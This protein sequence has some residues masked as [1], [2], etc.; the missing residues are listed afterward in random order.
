MKKLSAVLVVISDLH[1][2]NCRILVEDLK[3]VGFI[4]FDITNSSIWDKHSPIFVS[5]DD[6]E[7]VKNKLYYVKNDEDK[8]IFSRMMKIK[9]IKEC[10]NS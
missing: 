4:R 5:L 10:Q 2:P 8:L 1:G 6:Y 9:R 7:V 3:T